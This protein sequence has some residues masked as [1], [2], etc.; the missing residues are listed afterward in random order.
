MV[1]CMSRRIAVALYREIAT[2][3]PEWHGDGDEKAR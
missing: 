1:V 2:L 3:R